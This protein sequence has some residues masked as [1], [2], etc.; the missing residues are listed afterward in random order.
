MREFNH[1]TI[2][3]TKEAWKFLENYYRISRGFSEAKGEWLEKN[4]AR[5]FR[6]GGANP[7]THPIAENEVRIEHGDFLMK[8]EEIKSVLKDTGFEYRQDGFI[9]EG[10]N[11]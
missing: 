4:W 11:I 5:K 7:K 10:M 9:Q 3:I 6:N 2:I 1:E 8:I